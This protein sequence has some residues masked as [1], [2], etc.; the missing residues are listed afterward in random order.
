VDL[1][2]LGGFLASI[3]SIIGLFFAIYTVRRMN[4]KLET[5]EG[6]AETAGN[7]LRY[8]EDDEGNPLVDARLA[9]MISMFS[10][11]M[12]K[13]LRMGMLSGL[14][15]QGRLDKGLKG[16]IASDVVQNQMPLLN[17]IGDVMGINTMQYV[18]KHPDA[19]M[20]LAAKF[21]PQLAQLTQGVGRSPASR[22]NDGVGYG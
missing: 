1:A 22:G 3:T 12:A 15:V 16:A 14:G 11:A 9:K 8:E 2:L 19:M 13:S 7:F 18:K 20:Q 5:F 10:S 4:E 6:L 17:L 21:A